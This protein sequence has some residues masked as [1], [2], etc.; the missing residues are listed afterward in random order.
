MLKTIISFL[1]PLLFFSCASSRLDETY[2][3]EIKSDRISKVQYRDSIFNL[4]TKIEV[5]RSD[6]PLQLTYIIDTIKTKHIIK[7]KLNTNYTYGNLFFCW[8]YLIDLRNSKRF[9]YGKTIIFNQND[10]IK[11]IN[12]PIISLPTGK[13]FL[14]QFTKEYLTQKGNFKFTLS[15]PTACNFEM[16]PLNESIKKSVGFGISVG[17]DYYYIKNKYLSLN[18]IAF[19]DNFS[20]GEYSKNKPIERQYSSNIS[21][22]DNFKIKRFSV[23]YGLNFS[24][25]TWDLDKSQEFDTFTKFSYIK[26][27][28]YNFGF[29]I[30]GYYQ[31]L[32]FFYVGLNYRPT[33]LQ[34]Y[35]TTNFK[36]QH[37]LSIDY[38]FR[39][40]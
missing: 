6:K 31:L 7:P 20:I 30:T 17:L 24:K 12:E 39:F 27:V 15:I 14:K 35:P 11:I 25:N 33:I 18:L 22:S 21:L 13:D 28:N 36:Y 9:Y 40:N 19:V 1:I 29:V 37:V 16:R 10:S 8:G 4:P 26:K 34:T 23:G 2:K 32:R 5:F 3:L 38:Q